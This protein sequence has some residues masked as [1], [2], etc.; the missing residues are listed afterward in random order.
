MPEQNNKPRRVVTARRAL[1]LGASAA[2]LGAAAD[3]AAPTTTWTHAQSFVHRVSSEGE[4]ASTK[5]EGEGGEGGASSHAAESEGEGASAESEGGG[6]ATAAV[7]GGESEGGGGG[8]EAAVAQSRD[9]VLIGGLLRA[10]EALRAGGEDG[11]DHLIEEAA[12]KAEH[13]LHG[14]LAEELYETIEELEHA[15]SADAFAPVYARLA[16]E[17][18]EGE[19]AD[20]VKALPLALRVAAE[21]Y[22]D[23]ISDG[24]VSDRT[25]YLEAL[26]IYRAVGAEVEALAGSDDAEVAAVAAAMQAQLD[27]AAAAFDGPAGQNIETPDAS[28]LYAAAARME[29]AGLKLR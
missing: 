16:E 19:A 24:K 17:L 26:G 1:A 15:G 23:A 29:L 2:V 7:S 9:L 25:E 3:A 13:D 18:A 12:E 20:R 11:A 10:A 5:I 22:A 28:L 14:E 4:G 6:A 8:P 27:E 21:D